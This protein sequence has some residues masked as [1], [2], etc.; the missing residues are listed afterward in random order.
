M[1]N[2]RHRQVFGASGTDMA[3][4]FQ[5]MNAAYDAYEFALG[6]GP[7]T[8]EALAVLYGAATPAA[9]T[10]M[11]WKRYR[12]APRL[13]ASASA[14]P[15]AEQ[16]AELQSR[17]ARFVVCEHSL[18]GLAIAIANGVPEV[19]EPVDSVL[20]TMH[21]HLIAGITTVP[22]GVAAINQAQEA[23]FTYLPASL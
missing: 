5:E 8:L 7:G 9:I 21:A 22:S 11:P 1:A 6:E 19:E 10:G 4:L 18:Q 2:Q 20:Q 23:G 13:N 14:N 17:G 12:L 15:F 3:A 16:F